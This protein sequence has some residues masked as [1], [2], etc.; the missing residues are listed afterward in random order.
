MNAIE[1]EALRAA[2]LIHENV[3]APCPPRGPL[4]LPEQQWN[5]VHRLHRLLQLAHHRRLQ[6]AAKR[7]TVDLA[8]TLEQMQR[9]LGWTITGLEARKAPERI[10]AAADLYRDILA[11]HD[12]FDS[13]DINAKEHTLRVTTGRIV[14][15]GVRL[16]RFEICLDWHKL[17]KTPAYHVVALDPHAIRHGQ[18]SHSSPRPQ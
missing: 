11:L 18:R 16:G 8:D 4:Y 13:V 17:G 1:R 9:V 14:L 10:A 12:E 2:V 6:L 15:D 7:L 3:T 5:E